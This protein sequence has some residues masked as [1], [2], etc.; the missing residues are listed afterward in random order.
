[1]SNELK[2]K[3]VH[4]SMIAWAI[5]GRI[6]PWDGET[7]FVSGALFNIF[8]TTHYRGALL[9]ERG[10]NKAIPSVCWHTRQC[11]CLLVLVCINIKSSRMIAW[12]AMAFGDGGFCEYYWS[13]CS[14][15]QVRWS[16]QLKHGPGGFA[17]FGGCWFCADVL[18]CHAAFAAK[19]RAKALSRDL[20][21]NYWRETVVAG[22][23]VEPQEGFVDDNICC[24]T[25]F[26]T[27][28]CGW[29]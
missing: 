19:S 18:I 5:L 12:G 23:L 13:W 15:T 28:A 17:G 3:A 2:R 8:A 27:V 29:A 1:M 14:L 25:G 16:R 7:E 9:S 26:C 11:Y 4:V 6:E 22:A 20:D 21:G 24:S 10:E